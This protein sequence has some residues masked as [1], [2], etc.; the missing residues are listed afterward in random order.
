[1]FSLD[2]KQWQSVANGLLSS[3]A[4]KTSSQPTPETA[5]ENSGTDTVVYFATAKSSIKKSAAR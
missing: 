2:T 4:K 3:V 1:M 5:P